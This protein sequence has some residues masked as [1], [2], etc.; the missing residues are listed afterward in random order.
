[1]CCSNGNLCGSLVLK[2]TSKEGCFYYNE[3][4]KFT[5]GVIIDY[6]CVEFKVMMN[7]GDEITFSF[8]LCVVE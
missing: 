2:L 3:I 4:F 7:F 5:I 8:V 6:I 1:M